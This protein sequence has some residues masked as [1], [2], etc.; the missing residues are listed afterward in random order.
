MGYSIVHLK[1]IEGSGPGGAMRFVRRE[2]GVEAFWVNWLELPPNGVGH[3]HDEEDSQQ[4]EVNV[5]IRGSGSYRIDG[6]E[7]PAEQG[8]FFRFDPATTRVPVAGPEGMTLLAVGAR[9]G[10]YEPRGPF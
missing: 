6:E 7:V 5:V 2:L 4:E 10:S 1:D 3:E 9:R 8:M